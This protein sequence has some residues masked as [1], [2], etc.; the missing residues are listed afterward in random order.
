MQMGRDG[1][2][3]WAQEVRSVLGFFNHSVCM[4]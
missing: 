1:D 4:G 2:R 3:I